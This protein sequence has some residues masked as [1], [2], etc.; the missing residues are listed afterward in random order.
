[1]AEVA[2]TLHRQLSEI[3]NRQYQYL[4]QRL[5][6]TQ[7][8][9][10]SL[11]S[12]LTSIPSLDLIK[13][14]FAEHEELKNALS[15][16]Y[17]LVGTEMKTIHED[18]QRF[19][20]L[21]QTMKDD[22]RNARVATQELENAIDDY[23][24]LNPSASEF[25]NA[26]DNYDEYALAYRTTFLPRQIDNNGQP[27]MSVSSP[28]ISLVKSDEH[29]AT[30]A[31]EFG[32]MTIY[33][34]GSLSSATDNITI[35]GSITASE[36]KSDSPDGV[37][38]DN[39][40]VVMIRS[41][42]DSGVRMNKIIPISNAMGLTI[43]KAGSNN[44]LLGDTTI[45]NLIANDFAIRNIDVTGNLN[46]TGTTNL[47]TTNIGGASTLSGTT[48]IGSNVEGNTTT[49]QSPSTTINGDLKIQNVDIYGNTI[50]LLDNE[51]NTTVTGNLTHNGNMTHKQD[52]TVEGNLTA[53]GTTTLGNAEDE[54]NVTY[55]QSP[56]TYI[57]GT[58][59]S[60]GDAILGNSED[61]NNK[62]QIISPL[63]EVSGVLK[64]TNISDVANLSATEATIG[65][66][67]IT[68]GIDAPSLS[69]TFSSLTVTGET[70][71]NTATA[72]SI[73]IENSE[74]TDNVFEVKGNSSIQNI[75]DVESL[76]VNGSS[77]L[78][79]MSATNGTFSGNVDCE[80]MTTKTA[81]LPLYANPSSNEALKHV[82][83]SS[84]SSALINSEDMT[85]KDL[86]DA[87]NDEAIITYG[88]LKSIW[89]GGSGGPGPDAATAS[90]VRIL[91]ADIHKCLESSSLTEIPDCS[92]VS[93]WTALL[94]SVKQ[95][96][97]VMEY[98]L[99]TST[100]MS[101]E[102]VAILDDIQSNVDTDNVAT[103]IQNLNNIG[104]KYMIAKNFS[105]QASIF[106]TAN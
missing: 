53:K 80:S 5:D 76:T 58:L 98:S 89:S 45:E 63:T 17:I 102:D 4:I 91:N 101:E 46:V 94:Q 3:V 69:T 68:T 32:N 74:A 54:N 93:S 30:R 65:T 34:N 103:A 9:V 25:I 66:L 49:I 36:F 48:V 61:E 12:V 24:A 85:L 82:V 59:N 23:N 88:F 86:T 70:T 87:V 18:Y 26:I 55:I 72:K 81:N 57:T 6:K 43:G 71:M 44:Y 90:S 21:S 83:I 37:T 64:A 73:K 75:K 28:D 27:V 29:G 38:I 62:V 15:K 39:L 16:Y 100:P 20:E 11:Q 77:T 13:R 2:Y 104:K 56:K 51:G 42:D 19:I 22:I 8:D 35:N 10:G 92:S 47:S 50:H 52:V 33:N 79:A 106:S 67:H 1:M 40:R 97:N 96:A 60:T 84:D 41:K 7:Q 95:I 31:L 78:Q 14:A 99:M 105:E